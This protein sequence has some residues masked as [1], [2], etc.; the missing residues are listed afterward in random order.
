MAALAG[1][2]A[3]DPK[4]AVAAALGG[5]SQRQPLGATFAS[6]SD[7]VRAAL[8]QYCQTYNVAIN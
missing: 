4:Q 2:G 5:L 1:P 3:Q 8:Q 6:L 7:P